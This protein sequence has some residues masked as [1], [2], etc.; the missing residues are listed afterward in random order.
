M[1]TLLVLM[2]EEHP[3]VRE[4]ETQRGEIER[5]GRME[6]RLEASQPSVCPSSVFNDPQHLTRAHLSSLHHTHSQ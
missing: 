1:I 5:H 3:L 6:I 2:F 4:P